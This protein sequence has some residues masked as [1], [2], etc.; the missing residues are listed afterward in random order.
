M[1][2]SLNSGSSGSSYGAETPVKNCHGLVCDKEGHII[3]FNDHTKNNVIVYDKKGMLWYDA[4]GS[5]SGA[6]VQIATMSK[7]LKISA[8]DF[9]II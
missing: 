6:A 8:L 3:L 9:I 1:V 5:G 4:D 7:K 2:S